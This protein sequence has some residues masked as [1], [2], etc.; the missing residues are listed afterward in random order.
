MSTLGTVLQTLIV[1][2]IIVYVSYCFMRLTA[3]GLLWLIGKLSFNP[4]NEPYPHTDPTPL[5]VLRKT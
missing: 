3:Y 5:R 4:G 2:G 1:S